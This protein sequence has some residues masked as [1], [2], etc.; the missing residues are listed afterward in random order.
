MIQLF[1][2]W[3]DFIGW[4]RHQ[5]II[6][7]KPSLNVISQWEKYQLHQEAK[8]E[9]LGWCQFQIRKSDRNRYRSDRRNNHTHLDRSKMVFQMSTYRISRSC[10]PLWRSQ[11]LTFYSN[12]VYWCPNRH[13]PYLPRLASISTIRSTMISISTINVHIVHPLK[14]ASK[15]M[16]T[17]F[18]SKPIGVYRENLANKKHV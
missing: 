8:R 17:R 4:K 12:L 18:R 13:C 6:R 1:F 2:D 14:P 9:P 15:L 11:I 16:P 7:L 3:R 10:I 5:I